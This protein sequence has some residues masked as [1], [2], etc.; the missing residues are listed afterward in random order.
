MKRLTTRR[1]RQ[2]ELT[3]EQAVTNARAAWLGELDEFRREI[4]RI[5]RMVNSRWDAFLP[6]FRT[7]VENLKSVTFKHDKTLAFLTREISQLVDLPNPQMS[8]DKCPCCGGPRDRRV[9]AWETCT[10]LFHSSNTYPEAQ[11]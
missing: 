10:S 6:L 1:R 5:E 2:R 3:L 9:L 8:T 4:E 11:K 7:D